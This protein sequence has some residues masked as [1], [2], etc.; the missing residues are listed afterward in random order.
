MSNIFGSLL[1]YGGAVVCVAG[2]LLG[3]WPAQ[4]LGLGR[5]GGLLIAAVGI[6]ADVIA[7]RLPAEESHVTRAT[8]HLD[9]FVPRWQFNEYHQIRVAAPAARVYEAMKHVKANEIFLFKTLTWIR[10]GGRKQP[11][12]ILNAGDREPLI[13]VA[14]HNGFVSLADDPPRSWWSAR[15]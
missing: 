9:E 5:A 10:R 7:I 6:L 4:R 13:D 8:S 14:I 11:E 1:L 12:N 3:V 2:L 15:W